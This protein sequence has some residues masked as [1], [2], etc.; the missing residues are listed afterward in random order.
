MQLLS[1]NLNTERKFS[2]LLGACA[3]V[4]VRGDDREELKSDGWCATIPQLAIIPF[5][6]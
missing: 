2:I 1:S 3:R 5:L 6:C 4:R